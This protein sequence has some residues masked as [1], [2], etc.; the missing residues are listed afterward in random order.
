M[1]HS[2]LCHYASYVWD[3][4]P[5]HLVFMF[6]PGFWTPEIRVWHL[7]PVRFYRNAPRIVP[8][9]QNLYKL[10]KQYGQK[11]FRSSIPCQPNGPL[12]FSSDRINPNH[13]FGGTQYFWHWATAN[14]LLTMDRGIN[15]EK[16]KTEPRWTNTRHHCSSQ[17]QPFQYV[18]DQKG[19]YIL[20]SPPLPLRLYNGP[21]L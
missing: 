21:G 10:E 5:A 15:E 1:W 7:G 19:I 16:T 6:A 8:V 11:Q 9:D 2:I 12:R 3:L 13:G 18:S 20:K 4:V 14:N 17:K